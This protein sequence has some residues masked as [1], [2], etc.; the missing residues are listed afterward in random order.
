M[1]EPTGVDLRPWA[2]QR[3]YRWRYEESYHAEK[4][5]NRG[6]GSWY[7]E[8]LCKHGMIY[9]KGGK[10]L[11]AYASPRFKRRLAGLGFELHQTDGDCEVFRFPADR[12]DEVAAV[13]RPK[14]LAG[15]ATPNAKQLQTLRHA[16]V[17]A[18]F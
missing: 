2:K 11:L 16:R 3:R 12:L 6:D 5:E 7:V 9:P 4:P 15:T 1:I 18:G 17:S 10:T 8:V 13:L 14:R